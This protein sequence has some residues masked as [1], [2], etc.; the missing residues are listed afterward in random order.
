MDDDPLACFMTGTKGS[1]SE[2]SKKGQPCGGGKKKKN[3]AKKGMRQPQSYQ[4]VLGVSCGWN[5]VQF[6]DGAGRRQL[7]DSESHF[8]HSSLSYA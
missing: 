3:K 4:G 1:C 5:T 2:V 7:F 6:I 8:S